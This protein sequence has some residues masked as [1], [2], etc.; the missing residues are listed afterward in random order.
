MQGLTSKAWLRRGKNAA[1]RTRF[2]IWDYSASRMLWRSARRCSVKRHAI[3]QRGNRQRQ[4]Y[5]YL[6]ALT[7]AELDCRQPVVPHYDQQGAVFSNVQLS[8]LHTVP[9]D[10]YIKYQ[11]I[12][13]CWARLE[14]E[15]PTNDG[16]SLSSSAASWPLNPIHKGFLQDEQEVGFYT[17]C[18]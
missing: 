8:K 7:A 16:L 9:A 5:F 17:M 2:G 3:P 10:E 11:T 15:L 18:R 13:D 14:C 12:S 4:Y 6:G 1:V